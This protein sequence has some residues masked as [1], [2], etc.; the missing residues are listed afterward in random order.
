MEKITNRT[1]THLYSLMD[2]AYDASEIYTYITAQGRVAL[3][4]RNKRRN[5]TRKPMDLAEKAR[6]RIRSTVERS[7]SHLKDWLLPSKL[8]VRGY[9]KITFCL[10]TGVVCLAAL[11]ILQYFIVPILERST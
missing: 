2:A 4:D 1:I 3:I 10:M 8:M 5:D 11:K 9:S 7:N 6:F